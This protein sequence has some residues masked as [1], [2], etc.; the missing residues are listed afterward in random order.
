MKSSVR[1]M[2]EMQV[3]RADFYGS[4]LGDMNENYNVILS[5][6]LQVIILV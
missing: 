6:M 1:S 4:M 2:K 3:M 5:K